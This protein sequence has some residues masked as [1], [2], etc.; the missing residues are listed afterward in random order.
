MQ[1]ESQTRKTVYKFRRGLAFEADDTPNFLKILQTGE[2]HGQGQ[3]TVERQQPTPSSGP[4]SRWEEWDRAAG[5]GQ[6]WTGRCTDRVD[7][8]PQ[9]DG[10]GS[11]CW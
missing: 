11:H 1:E 5:G 2:W 6:C 7:E 10:E 4:G 9:G 3:T 8:R